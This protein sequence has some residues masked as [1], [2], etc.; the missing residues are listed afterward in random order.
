[1]TSLLR[2]V[3]MYSNQGWLLPRG[4]CGIHPHQNVTAL[5]K[6][7]WVSSPHA[8]LVSPPA[9]RVHPAE[10]WWDP[11]LELLLVQAHCEIL[12]DS[13]ITVIFLPY[14]PNMDCL[15]AVSCE[16]AR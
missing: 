9:R 1:M 14:S 11:M 16:H 12:R 13:G 2:N 3:L 6:T 10:L 8:K 15:Q 5:R 4:R 7:T